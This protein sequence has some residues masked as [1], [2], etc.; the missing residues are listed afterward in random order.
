MMIQLLRYNIFMKSFLNLVAFIFLISFGS[1]QSP[2]EITRSSSLNFKLE[3]KEIRSFVVIA[4]STDIM[5]IQIGSKRPINVSIKDP[6]GAIRAGK[7]V[8]GNSYSW[9]E[10]G[11]T[12]GAWEITIENLFSFSKA[13]VKVVTAITKNNF[14]YGSGDSR[15]DS[16]ISERSEEILTKGTFRVKKANPLS[17]PVPVLKGDTLLVDII[18][19][20]GKCPELSVANDLGEWLHASLSAREEKVLKI[21]IL[22]DGAYDIGIS[23]ASLFGIFPSPFKQVFNIKLS[24]ISP[25]RYALITE[26]APPADP[27]N[28]LDTISEVY[29]DTII[30][31]GATRDIIHSNEGVLKIRFRDPESILFWV[32][33]YGVGSAYLSQMKTLNQVPYI[34]PLT[35]LTLDP[36]EAY[37]LGKRKSLPRSIDGQVQFFLSEDIAS[38]LRGKNY[39]RVEAFYDESR[40]K[41]L[42]KSKNVGQKVHVKVVSYRTMQK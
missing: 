1:A 18:P 39:G 9:I 7:M 20:S 25:T 23:G 17:F 12:T 33:S 4:D 36:L 21:P 19:E 2:I 15:T 32:I 30:S 28:I 8:L 34:D 37:A 38:A 5:G 27:K 26:E 11:G 24:K 13:K 3:N 41:M 35:G 29:M 42:N 16:L 6:N 31:L 14:I 22:A 40:M 10:F